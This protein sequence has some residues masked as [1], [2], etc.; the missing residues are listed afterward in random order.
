MK[1]MFEQHPIAKNLAVIA[2]ILAGTTLCVAPSLSKTTPNP[3]N[4]VDEVWQILDRSYVDPTFNH[5]DW[6]AVRREYL[7]RNYTSKQAAYRAIDSMVAKLGDR[8]TSFFDPQEYQELNNDID[9]EISGVGVKIAV[10]RKTNALIATSTVDGSP[11]AKSG[12]LPNDIILK[13]DGRS[14]KQMKIQDVGKGIMGAVGTKVKLTVQRG[15]EVKTFTMTRAKIN[16]NPVTY[17]IR[18]TATGKIGYIRLPEFTKTA[19]QQMALAIRSLEQQHVRGYVLD[20]R[21]DP[22]GLVTASLDVANMWLKQ[23]GIVSIVDRNQAKE[24]YESAGHPLTDK[25]LVVLVDRNSAS[26]SEILA[27][28][29]QDDNRATLVGTRTFGKGLVQ[30]VQQLSDGSALKV[31]VAKY[32]TPKG[33]DINH[34]GIVPDIAADLPDRQL[35]TLIQNHTAGTLVDLQYVTAVTDLDR[36]IQ[37]QVSRPQLSTQ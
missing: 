33:R 12:I 32:Y 15:S 30:A 25:P 34:V 29:L 11:A 8:Y 28:A 20:L 6:Q 9:G 1:V 2:A 27:G 13:I 37:T 31:T 5:Q 17:S 35:N 10:E 22:G 19:P 7:S 26:A 23:G 14:T 4:L 3:K 24:S 18:S 21:D 16:S 36:V